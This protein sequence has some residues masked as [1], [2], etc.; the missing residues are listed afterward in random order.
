[1]VTAEQPHTL[2][3][4][5][6]NPCRP[7]CSANSVGFGRPGKFRGEYTL[8]ACEFASTSTGANDVLLAAVMSKHRNF[9]AYL[10]GQTCQQGF[11]PERKQM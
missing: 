6:L 2:R 3:V 10:H 4:L 7:K 11:Y 1:M 5:S 9:S 8:N